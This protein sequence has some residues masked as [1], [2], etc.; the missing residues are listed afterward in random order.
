MRFRTPE[1]DAKL[2]ELNG[3]G[4]ETLLYKRFGPDVAFAYLATPR[5]FGGHVI[6]LLQMP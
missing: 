3:R 4:F 1:I 2:A 6:E 5:E